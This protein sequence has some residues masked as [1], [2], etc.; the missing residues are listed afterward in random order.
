MHTFESS[1][2]G[3]ILQQFFRKRDWKLPLLPLQHSVSNTSVG[4]LSAPSPSRADTN[5][6]APTAT[7]DTDLDLSPQ[8]NLALREEVVHFVTRGII[9]SVEHY[10]RHQN[11]SPTSTFSIDDK[12]VFMDY[13]TSIFHK[14]RRLYHISDEEYV[15]YISKPTKEKLAEGNSGAFMFYCGNG[16]LIVKTITTSEVDTLLEILPT[17]YN[18]LM[19]NSHSL[20]VKFFGL[21]SLQMYNQ[22][23]YFIVM[24]NVFPSNVIV[25]QRYDIKGSW[26][27]RNTGIIPPGKR[28]FCRHCGELFV[29]GSNE[30]CPDIVGPHDPNIILKDNDMV[31]KI[32][33]KPEDAYNLI[34]ILLKDS[35]ALCAMGITDYSMLVGVKNFVYDLDHDNI[36]K[37]Y[38]FVF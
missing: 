30:R 10:V 26:V 22:T 21:H 28:I 1:A 20:L 9:Q 4:S 14:L 29:S 32:R 3:N 38:Y 19:N 12:H 24:R 6:A 8:L 34:D 37:K 15:H 35:D 33:L 5:S 25:N 2:D 23:F 7:D 31:N 27:N 11:P 17:Y 13:E 16:E 18:Y 36:I